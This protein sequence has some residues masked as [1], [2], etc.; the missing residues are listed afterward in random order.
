MLNGICDSWRPIV[1]IFLCFI[2]QKVDIFT[3]KWFILAVFAVLSAVTW[4]ENI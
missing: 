4:A 2:V 3:E 1:V